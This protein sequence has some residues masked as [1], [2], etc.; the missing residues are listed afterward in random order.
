[1]VTYS[2]FHENRLYQQDFRRRLLTQH[3][4]KMLWLKAILIKLALN[5]GQNG[6]GHN[7]PNFSTK[8]QTD[9]DQNDP[10]RKTPSTLK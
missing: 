1:M 4:H 10:V 3:K 7:S 5:L 6:P 8:G 2:P 9:S